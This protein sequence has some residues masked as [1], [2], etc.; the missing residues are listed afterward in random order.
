MSEMLVH[1]QYYVILLKAITTEY[2]VPV[3]PLI[4]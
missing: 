4:T 3:R 2:C 1:I